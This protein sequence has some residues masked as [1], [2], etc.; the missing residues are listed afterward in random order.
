MQHRRSDAQRERDELEAAAAAA[1]RKAGNEAKLEAWR[2]ETLTRAGIPLADAE[3]LLNWRVDVSQAA[4]YARQGAS[5]EQI[6][7]ILRPVDAREAS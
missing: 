5:S 7:A 1:E 3:V 2:L 6:L 4:S